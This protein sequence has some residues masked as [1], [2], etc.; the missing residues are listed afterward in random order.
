[1]IA[2]D[3]DP[4][5]NRS[6]SPLRLSFTDDDDMVADDDRTLNFERNMAKKK[7]IEINLLVFILIFF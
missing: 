2:T 3:D 7:S 4:P 1:M 6:P 5:N